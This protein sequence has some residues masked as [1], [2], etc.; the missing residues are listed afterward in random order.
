MRKKDSASVYRL[1]CGIKKN[2]SPIECCF[3]FARSRVIS[4]KHIRIGD[5][6]PAPTGVDSLGRRSA[7]MP[8][9]C[10]PATIGV[11]P[12]AQEKASATPDMPTGRD[13]ARQTHKTANPLTSSRFRICNPRTDERKDESSPNRLRFMSLDPGHLGSNRVASGNPTCRPTLLEYTSM[14]SLPR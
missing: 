11:G 13:R 6:R 9:Q 10:W 1:F 12:P 7:T 3:L 5:D 4:L 2:A 14:R 8:G